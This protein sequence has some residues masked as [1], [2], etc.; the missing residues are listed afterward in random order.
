MVGRGGVSARRSVPRWVQ[1]QC[2]EA[3]G[4]VRCS[5]RSFWLSAFTIPVS[6]KPD[7]GH[8]FKGLADRHKENAERICQT[9]MKN[10]KSTKSDRGTISVSLV[11][12]ALALARVPGFEALPLAEAA[13]IAATMLASP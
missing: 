11:E 3:T 13:A 9:A 10:L 7:S 6:C 8:V 4:Q 1:A 5:A 2:R 12:E